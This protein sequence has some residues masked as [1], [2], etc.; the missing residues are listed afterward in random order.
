MRSVPTVAHPELFSLQSAAAH[1]RPAVRRLQ[2]HDR[3]TDSNAVPSCVLHPRSPE[4]LHPVSRE[5]KYREQLRYFK[6]SKHKLK[7][8]TV[9]NRVNTG[10]DASSP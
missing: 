10:K 3:R 9:I 6:D 2:S 4:N 1:M 8:E 7:S 5:R